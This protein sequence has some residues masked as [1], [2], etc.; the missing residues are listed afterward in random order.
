MKKNKGITLIALVITIIV[1]LVLVGVTIN[2]AVNGGLFD[3]AAKASSETKTKII[4]EQDYINI[5]NG[6][7]QKELIDQYTLYQ[8]EKDNW[9]YTDVDKDG[10]INIGDMLTTGTESFYVI[11]IDSS[12]IKLLAAQ[13]VDPETNKQGNSASASNVQFDS[14]TPYSNVYANS[15]IKELLD[16]YVEG[17]GVKIE[18]AR[19]MRLEE[20]VELGGD[21]ENNTVS[22]CP[23][24][25]YAVQYTLETPWSTTTDSTWGIGYK[26]T[27]LYGHWVYAHTGLRPVIIISTHNINIITDMV[28]K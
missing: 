2:I 24:F 5:N 8:S 6:L 26:T 16:L 25:I 15:T 11:G 3:Y 17:L 14:T 28:K 19:L 20:V 23:S 7:T 12:N 13:K 27:G 1:M 22:N 4:K 21:P 10:T 9:E 18:E